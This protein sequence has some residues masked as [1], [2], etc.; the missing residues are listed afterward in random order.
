MPSLP[1]KRWAAGKTVCHGGDKD[2]ITYRQLLSWFNRAGSLK[3]PLT[4]LILTCIS[5]P[6]SSCDTRLS[7]CGT[8]SK[9][10]CCWSNT[11]TL[12]SQMAV[13]VFESFN[14]WQCYRFP[15]FVQISSV[16]LFYPYNTH[17][18]PLLASPFMSPVEMTAW[19]FLR[20][21]LVCCYFCYSDFEEGILVGNLSVFLSSPWVSPGGDGEDVHIMPRPRDWS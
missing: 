9:W 2:F 12:I 3:H 16:V 7:V 1:L 6:L 18:V 4:H 5:L 15:E 10:P 21:H 19:S 11:Q 20:P 13:W 8:N 17:T 14:S